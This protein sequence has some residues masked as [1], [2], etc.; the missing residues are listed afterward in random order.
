ME[1]SKMADSPICSIDGCDKPRA[2]RGLCQKHYDSLRHAGLIEKQPK[3][4]THAEYLRRAVATASGD[5]CIFW[6]FFRNKSGQAMVWYEG[7][8]HYAPRLACSWAHGEPISQDLAAAHSCG[9]GHLGCINPSHLRWATQ[10]ENNAERWDDAYA[11][12]RRDDERQPWSKLSPQDVRHIRADTRGVVELAD[13]YGV[14][15]GTISMIRTRR[16]WRRIA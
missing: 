13:A 14:T 9:N 6:P 7:R 3:K 5:D 15:P 2:T 8:S 11:A 12:I 16:T 1:G 10:A 4:E